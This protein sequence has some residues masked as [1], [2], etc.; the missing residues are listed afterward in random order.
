[1]ITMLW[2]YLIIIQVTAI[3][4]WSLLTGNKKEN[5]RNVVVQMCKGVEIKVWLK[6][7]K[8][9]LSLFCNLDNLHAII[10]VLYQSM[11]K[12]IDQSELNRLD[13]H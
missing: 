6:L 5:T 8:A 12:L 1:M 11:C 9:C 3:I 4:N 7:K 10:K 13:Y 2:C